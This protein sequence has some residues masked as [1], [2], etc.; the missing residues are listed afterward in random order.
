LKA[1]KKLIGLIVAAVCIAAVVLTIIMLYSHLPKTF[2]VKPFEDSTLVTT[3]TLYVPYNQSVIIN[4][5]E[6]A[7]FTRYGKEVNVTVIQATNES[8]ARYLFEAT[9]ISYL[10]QGLIQ[11]NITISEA[12]GVEFYNSNRPYTVLLVR[13]NFVILSC[14]FYENLAIDAAKAQL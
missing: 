4:A 3:R 14:S 13:E 1:S 9:K 8:T 6:Q 10:A 11:E 7:S 12:Q 5:A 2:L